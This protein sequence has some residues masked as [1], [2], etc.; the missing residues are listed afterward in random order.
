MFEKICGLAIILSIF[1]FTKAQN[2]TNGTWNIFNIRHNVNENWN[3]FA[4]AQLRSLD[5][6]NDFNYYEVKGGADRKLNKNYRLAL[7]I[8]SYQTYSSDGNFTLP[9]SNN[10]FRIWPQ[11]LISHTLY[12]LK[13]EQRI[14]AE[15][16]FNSNEYRNRFR[17]RLALLYPF[18]NESKGYKPYQ[19]FINNEL[20]FTDTQKRF[21]RNRI[22]VGFNFKVNSSTT[23]QTGYINQIDF[24]T[25]S[26][27]R[28]NFIQLGVFY[29][30]P[31]KKL[32][33]RKEIDAQEN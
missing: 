24:K 32:I 12:N 6:Y 8:G 2:V 26:K 15:F 18:G 21:E 1:S 4:E 29:E 14:R 31:N 30:I 16:R 27:T 22:N 17:Y 7:G 33:K 20:F 10:E 19:I 5:F 9:K 28:R 3:V 23:L 11:L 25:D 13:I